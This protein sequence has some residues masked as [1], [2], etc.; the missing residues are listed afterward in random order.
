MIKPLQRQSPFAYGAKFIFLCA[1][2][3]STKVICPTHWFINEAAL[4]IL[5]SAGYRQDANAIFPF[6]H[7]LQDGVA[8]ADSGYKNVSHFFN[9]VTKKGIWGFASAACD[10]I[11][12]L[13]KATQKAH[14]GNLPDAMFYVGAAAHLLQDLCVPHHTCGLLFAGHKE[15]EGW[16]EQN[17]MNYLFYT[18]SIEDHFKKPFHLLFSNAVAS[19][20]TIQLVNQEDL[21]NY[22][23]AT[24]FLLPLAEYSTAGLLHWFTT[25]LKLTILPASC[26]MP[27]PLLPTAIISQ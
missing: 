14:H 24:K 7:N 9:P 27:L 23:K 5:S 21:A 11:H 8:W 3:L 17:Y 19:A 26:L 12:Y 18:D 15:Y 20:A 4:D 10:F 6:L 2:P 13:N 25:R 22:D 16:V 1:R